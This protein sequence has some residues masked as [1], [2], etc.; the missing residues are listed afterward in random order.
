MRR[1][2]TWGLRVRG[3][4]GAARRDRDLADEIDAHLQLHIDDN[5]RAGMTATEARRR[6]I[7]ALGGIDQT[8]EPYRDQRGIP[9]VSHLIR[10]TRYGLRT[11][12]RNPGFAAAAI[13]TLGLGLG[14]NMAM[15]RF[16]DAVLLKS[17]PIPNPEQLVLIRPWSFSY[18]AFREIAA[19]NADVLS[20][21][22]GALDD[23]R[24]PDTGRHHRVPAGR[25]RQRELLRHAAGE[26][27]DRASAH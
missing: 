12:R 9:A 16:V 13:V 8:T 22:H 1:L 19:R 11:L 27:G 10:D 14:A 17:L 7:L 23:P 20:E 6:A 26:T 5:I 24:Q 18:P 4:F 2:R 25:A 3:T 21:H 15:F